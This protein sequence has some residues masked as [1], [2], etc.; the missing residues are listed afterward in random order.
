MYKKYDVLREGRRENS[1]S[2]AEGQYEVP[3]G[4]VRREVVK[5]DLLREEGMEDSTEG[6]SVGPAGPEVLHLNIL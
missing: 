4:I 3:L 2:H 6:Q 1:P 5:W